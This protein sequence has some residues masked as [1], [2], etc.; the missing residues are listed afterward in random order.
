VARP[1]SEDKSRA[2]LE[3]AVEVFAERGTGAATAAISKAAGVAE[4]TLFT[5]FKTKDELINAL[6]RALKLEVA[7]EMLAGPPLGSDIRKVLRRLWDGNIR[8]AMANPA[9]HKVLGQLKV[10]ESVSPSA[11]EAGGK[12]FAELEAL[13]KDA[14]RRKILRNYPME[15]MGMLLVSITDATL[16]YLAT[17]PNERKATA[18][19]GFEALWNA[20]AHP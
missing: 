7:A 4:G 18:D 19:R 15:F 12:P 2:I 9:K 6:Y 14:M 20:I 1:K 11:R 10:S 8:W 5:Y 3:A 17:H 16:A 13:L